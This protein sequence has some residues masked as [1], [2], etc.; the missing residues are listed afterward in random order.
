MKSPEKTP[1]S[2]VANASKTVS[3]AAPTVD[4]SAAALKGME[5]EAEAPKI[6]LLEE[7]E[8]VKAIEA[9]VWFS[10]KRAIA[11]YTTCNPHNSWMGIARVG[12]KKLSTANDS[13]CEAMTLL[14]SQCREKNCRIDFSEENNQVKEMYVW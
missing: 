14:A 13:S 8:A 9:A 7:V 4:I 1:P 5:I 2:V 12:W 10:D 11:L 6:K 3:P